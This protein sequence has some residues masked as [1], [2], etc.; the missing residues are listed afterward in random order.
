MYTAPP[1]CITCSEVAFSRWRWETLR[2]RAETC[3]REKRLGPSF[4]SWS[5]A[6]EMRKERDRNL[7]RAA[8]LLR[9]RERILAFRKWKRKTAAKKRSRS[10]IGCVLGSYRVHLL[11]IAFTC[12]ARE[13]ARLAEIE[14][15]ERE[16]LERSLRLCD[17][18][19]RLSPTRG[20]RSS[21]R[22]PYTCLPP[23]HLQRR[24]LQAFRVADEHFDR[25]KVGLEA[26]RDQK[27]RTVPTRGGM[28]SMRERMREKARDRLS[29][30]WWL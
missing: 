30:T 23:D 20:P 5:R 29:Q 6:P 21:T 24:L 10:T 13:S 27:I 22:P 1:R 26:R 28:R 18:V 3:F 2:R 19:K 12:W 7:M 11:G 4:R 25:L 14:R 16:A 15:V 9:D 17:C 8:R